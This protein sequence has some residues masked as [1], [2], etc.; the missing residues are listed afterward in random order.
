[1][2]L[3]GL[4]GLSFL[5]LGFAAYQAQVGHD[6]TTFFLLWAFALTMMAHRLLSYRRIR[7]NVAREAR[8]G[9]SQW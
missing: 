3:K 6:L 2:I 5:C 9:S 7:Q 1:M 4:W 8:V